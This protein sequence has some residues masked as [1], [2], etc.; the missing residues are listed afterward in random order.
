MNEATMPLSRPK[1]ADGFELFGKYVA[2][3]LRYIAIPQTQQ[4]AK[5]QI[6]TTL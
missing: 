3:E 5:F 6:Q 4:W 1:K 2:S